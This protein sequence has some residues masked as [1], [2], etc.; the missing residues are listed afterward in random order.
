MFDSIGRDLD[1]GV[2][3][4]QARSA[5][6]TSILSGALGLAL[7]AAGMWTLREEV[8]SQ[9]AVEI[10]ELVLLEEP[11]PELPTPP[12]PK[13][14][15][16][17]GPSGLRA[18]APKTEPAARPAPP[19]TSPAQL[20]DDASS[21]TIADQTPTEEGTDRGNDV[22]DMQGG[23][24]SE[25]CPGCTPTGTGAPGVG[26]GGGGYEVVR[27]DD[28]RWRKRI[29]PSYPQA[30]EALRLADQRCLTTVRFDAEGAPT[31]VQI[32]DCA[33]PLHGAVRDAMMRSRVWPLRVNGVAIRTE[34]RIVFVFRRPG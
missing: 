27:H 7:T 10:F 34:T 21:N 16:S 33:L 3:A 13:V 5:L 32:E 29:D 28:L 14:G 17:A 25:G 31:D 11:K 2:P 23:P 1:G 6:I 20:H 9:P 18:P 4:R 15:S 12:E 30:A 8:K 22:G 19:P 24:T 26:D